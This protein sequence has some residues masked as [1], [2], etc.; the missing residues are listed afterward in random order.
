VRLSVLFFFFFVNNKLVLI[1]GLLIY[2][3]VVPIM[4]VATMDMCLTSNSFSLD[5]LQ[6]CVNQYKYHYT[7]KW[8]VL[9]KDKNLTLGSN[10]WIT[11]FPYKVCQGPWGRCF[12]QKL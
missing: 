7:N 5:Q 9:K 11:S 10:I 3:V 4:C 12:L 2:R 6:I 1:F 8:I